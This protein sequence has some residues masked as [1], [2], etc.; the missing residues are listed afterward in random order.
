[1]AAH[2]GCG[3]LGRWAPFRAVRSSSVL[4][5]AEEGRDSTLF[6]RPREGQDVVVFPSLLPPGITHSA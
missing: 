2:W 6:R 3:L 1:M 4:G 5:A